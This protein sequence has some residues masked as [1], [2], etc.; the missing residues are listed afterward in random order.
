MSRK[1]QKQG[2][3]GRD[4]WAALEERW[5]QQPRLRGAL[6]CAGAGRAPFRVNLAAEEGRVVWSRPRL[7]LPHPPPGG[8]CFCLSSWVRGAAAKALG[9]PVPR[10]HCRDAAG[11]T[12]ARSPAAGL[13]VINPGHPSSYLLTAA[14][15]T[16]T[17][18]SG[19]PASGSV[20]SDVP[21]PPRRG[22]SG[23]SKIGRAHV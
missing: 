1:A 14:R 23:L 13:S 5:S 12:G 7:D 17:A 3:G 22:L 11:G 8:R 10:H 20:S 6:G 16:P 4:H 9:V 2:P 18:P 21:E 15:R 19:A